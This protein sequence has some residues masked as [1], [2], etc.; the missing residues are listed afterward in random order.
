MGGLLHVLYPIYIFGGAYS[1]K[2]CAKCL[3]VVQPAVAAI[4][5]DIG[6]IFYI[7]NN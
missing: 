3:E 6:Q 1:L 4:F 5:D 2:T 7:Y